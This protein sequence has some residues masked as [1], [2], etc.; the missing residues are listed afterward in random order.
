MFYKLN[1]VKSQLLKT[2]MRQEGKLQATIV[3]Q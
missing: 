3:F 2:E 1:D